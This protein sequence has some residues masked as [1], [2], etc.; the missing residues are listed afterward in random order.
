MMYI[1]CL[2][3]KEVLKKCEQINYGS[4][5]GAVLTL[6]DVLQH[7]ETFLVVITKEMLLASSR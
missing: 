2:V 6:G 3:Q 1:V 5:L 4:Q 7:Q